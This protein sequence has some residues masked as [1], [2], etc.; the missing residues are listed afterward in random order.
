MEVKI[1]IESECQ[2]PANQST[3]FRINLENVECIGDLKIKLQPLLKVAAC[4][5]SVYYQ[6]E[7]TWNQKLENSQKISNLYVREGDRFI[8]K[9]V[10]ICKFDVL[11]HILNDLKTFVREVCEKYSEMEGIYNIDEGSSDKV[12]EINSYYRNV[13]EDL[14]WCSYDLFVPWNY[15]PT[16]ANRHYFAQEGGLQLLAKIHNFASKILNPFGDRYVCNNS[17]HGRGCLVVYT[18]LY[19]FVPLVKLTL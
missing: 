18:G 13:I 7:T 1:R 10:S 14:E 5:M 9:F 4:D 6:T 8:V 15:R 17:V 12:S 2:L 11:S 16:N 3:D 19:I